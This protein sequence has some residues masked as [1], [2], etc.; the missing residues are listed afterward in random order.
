[1]RPRRSPPRIS[2]HAP[3]RGATVCDGRDSCDLAGYFNPRPLA[4]SDLCKACEARRAADFNPRPLAGERPRP[5]SNG[6]WTANF[7]PRPL[8]GAT[9]DFPRARARHGISIHTLDR[10]FDV[11]AGQTWRLLSRHISIHAPLAGS[12]RHTPARQHDLYNFNPR[13]PRGERRYTSRGCSKP[14]EYFNP[15]PPRG[16]RPPSVGRLSGGSDFNPR[17]PRGERPRPGGHE[18]RKEKFQSTPPSRGATLGIFSPPVYQG[19]SIHAPLAGSD[20]EPFQDRLKPS[21]FQSTPPSRGATPPKEIIPVIT[22]FQSTPPSRGA[23]ANT[24]KY[25]LQIIVILHKR[26]LLKYLGGALQKQ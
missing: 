15:R 13:P 19:I 5:P 21:R 18:G 4:G 22:V 14:P 1:M 24:D 17:P 25:P 11:R 3:L 7:N 6:L 12:D 23:T 26:I 8:A 20:T 16:E 2:I 10:V 9:R